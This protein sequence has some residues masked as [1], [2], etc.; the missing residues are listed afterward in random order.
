MQQCC[1][2]TCL[3]IWIWYYVTRIFDV[4]K[5]KI[6]TNDIS[7]KY[8]IGNYK[9]YFSAKNWTWLAV[10]TFGFGIDSDLSLTKLKSRIKKI[11]AI[12]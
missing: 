2:N 9:I 5:T 4:S 11:S 1:K 7:K 10:N 8:S 3:N 12:K 6:M